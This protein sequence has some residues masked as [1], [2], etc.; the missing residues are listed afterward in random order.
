[1]LSKERWNACV[2]ATTGS[3]ERNFW[4]DRLKEA[5]RKQEKTIIEA[6]HCRYKSP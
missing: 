2:M 6:A 1:M 5:P 4:G 3:L